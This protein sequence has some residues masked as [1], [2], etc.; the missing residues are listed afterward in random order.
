MKRILNWLETKFARH[1]ATVEADELHTPVG[2]A[3]VPGRVESHGSEKDIQKPNI[4]NC[5][6]P[7]KQPKL[8]IR[9]KSSLVTSESMGVDPYN[10]G[11]FDTSKSRESRSRK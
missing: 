4:Y 7:F 3:E 9:Y 8:T 11:S 6:N 10:T 1:L 5:D 2:V